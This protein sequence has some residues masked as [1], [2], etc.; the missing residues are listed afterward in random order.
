MYGV[1]TQGTIKRQDY[2]KETTN[3]AKTYG[4]DFM[5]HQWSPL[6]MNE[7]EDVLWVSYM[8]QSP[9]VTKPNKH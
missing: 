1:T 9:Y 6:C 7:L 5:Q 4:E 3:Q 8:V 2:T